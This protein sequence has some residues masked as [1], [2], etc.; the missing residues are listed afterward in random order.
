MTTCAVVRS[1]MASPSRR[2]R[3]RAVPA[4]RLGKPPSTDTSL[5]PCAGAPD[6]SR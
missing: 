6:S 1:S 4:S 5:A 3:S 2:S